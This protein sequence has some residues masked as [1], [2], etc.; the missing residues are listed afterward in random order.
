MAH[1]IK[2]ISQKAIIRVS[3]CFCRSNGGHFIFWSNNVQ[4]SSRL[5]DWSYISNCASYCMC[6]DCRAQL[7]IQQLYPHNAWKRRRATVRNEKNSFLWRFTYWERALRKLSESISLDTDTPQIFCALQKMS[8]PDRFFRKKHTK[9]LFCCK[10]VKFLLRKNQ[11]RFNFRSIP[12]IVKESHHIC[13]FYSLTMK[14]FG[15]DW[16]IY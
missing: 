8:T 1:K 13:I 4:L 14:V 2:T 7:L 12:Y 15:L 5:C 16:A 11:L 3:D 6:I 9:I 10:N